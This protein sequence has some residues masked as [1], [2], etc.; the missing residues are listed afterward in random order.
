MIFC[1]DS[2]SFQKFGSSALRFSS[3][4]RRV[5]ASTSKMPPQQSHGLLDRL[6]ERFGFGAH[7]WSFAEI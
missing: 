6:G 7:F 2:V 1:A 5:A 3:A 4:K